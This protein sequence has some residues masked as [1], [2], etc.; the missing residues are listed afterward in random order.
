MREKIRECEI[1]DNVSSSLYLARLGEKPLGDTTQD[2]V[3]DSV[4]LSGMAS[5]N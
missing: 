4:R 5:S 3:G 1:G 2:I